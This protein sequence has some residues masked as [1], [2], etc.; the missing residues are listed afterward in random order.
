MEKDRKLIK[1]TENHVFGE[2]YKEEDGTKMKLVLQQSN[3][4]LFA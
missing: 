3:F 4:V 1:W 2:L